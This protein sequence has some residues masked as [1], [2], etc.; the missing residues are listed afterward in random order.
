MTSSW[1]KKLLPLDVDIQDDVDN[2]PKQSKTYTPTQE[3]SPTQKSLFH[4]VS[5][6]K[7]N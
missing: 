4:P 6:Y 7:A 5:I 3:Q 1:L 2:K